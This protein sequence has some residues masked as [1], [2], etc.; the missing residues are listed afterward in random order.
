MDHVAHPLLF[1]GACVVGGLGVA[2]ALPR[3]GISPRA[4]GAII[5]AAGGGL[6]LLALGLRNPHARPNI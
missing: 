6:A 1:Y 4:I 5:A 2:L 3:R